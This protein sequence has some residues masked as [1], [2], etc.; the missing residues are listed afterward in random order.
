MWN[1]IMSWFRDTCPICY[2][3]LICEESGAYCCTVK[4]CPE[5]HYRLERHALI[6]VPVEYRLE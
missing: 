6:G 2:E 3:N 5:G 1:R 4:A